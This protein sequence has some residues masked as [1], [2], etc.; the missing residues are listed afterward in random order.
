MEVCKIGTKYIPTWQ[1]DDEW[2]QLSATLYCDK[3]KE[4]NILYSTHGITFFPSRNRNYNAWSYNVEIN[5]IVTSS[6]YSVLTMTNCSGKVISYSMPQGDKRGA[7]YEFYDWNYDGEWRGDS[8]RNGLG[9]LTDS[10]LGPADYKLGYYA[11][12]EII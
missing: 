6:V 1:G 9:A 2:A 3:N 5:C 4:N 8:L 10:N 12:S 11:K 7:T